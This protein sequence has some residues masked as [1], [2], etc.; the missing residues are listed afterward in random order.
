MNKKGIALLGAIPIWLIVIAV[1]M[2]IVGGLVGD[3]FGAIITLLGIAFVFVAVAKIFPFITFIGNIAVF[4]FLLSVF[5]SLQGLT[6]FQEFLNE[7]PYFTW[8]LAFSMGLV[9]GGFIAG[10]LGI[11][12]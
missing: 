3:T 12:K 4:A 10:I 6:D 5:L 8:A 1:A 7:L 9:V 2:I 11:K